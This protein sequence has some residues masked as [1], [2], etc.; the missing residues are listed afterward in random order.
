MDGKHSCL[1]PGVRNDAGNGDVIRM[2]QAE[3]APA[4]FC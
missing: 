1:A 3:K 4:L 2:Y